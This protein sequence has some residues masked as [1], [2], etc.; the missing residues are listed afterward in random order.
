MS[1]QLTPVTPGEAADQNTEEGSAEAKQQEVT[2]CV[3]G[4][5]KWKGNCCPVKVHVVRPLKNKFYLFFY[6]VE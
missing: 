4:A 6:S 2:V 1:K 3:E 5:R